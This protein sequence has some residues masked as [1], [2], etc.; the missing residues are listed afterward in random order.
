MDTQIALLRVLQ[1]R[2]IERL[3]GNRPIPVDVRVLA[4]THTDM[5]AAVSAGTLREDLYYRL[6]VFPIHL[7]PLRER[8][9]DV[10]ALVEYSIDRFAKKAA[11]NIRRIDKR[12]MDR[13]QAYKW[14]G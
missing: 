9:S 6:N 11:K 12:T 13:L 10:P 8:A 2:E 3:G 1:E 4:A 7:P 14:A 5:K